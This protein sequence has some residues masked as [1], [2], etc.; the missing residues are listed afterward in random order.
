MRHMSQ[1]TTW[2]ALVLQALQDLPA[3]FA[4]EE[5]Y[6]YKARMAEHHP[7]NRFVEEKIRQVLQGLRDDGLL[8]FLGQGRY[9]RLD[10]TLSP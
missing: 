10:S 3:E 2:R 9:R 7:N 8:E 4:L 1:R 5:I 6:Q